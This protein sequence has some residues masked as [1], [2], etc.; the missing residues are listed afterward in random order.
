MR[1]VVRRQQNYTAAKRWRNVRDVV[2]RRGPTQR[3][4]VAAVCPRRASLT[5]VYCVSCRT[6]MLA[7]AG[8]PRL[9]LH[10]PTSILVAGEAAASWDDCDNVISAAASVATPQLHRTEHRP[11]TCWSSSF[12][13]PSA[14]SHCCI[15]TACLIPAPAMIISRHRFNNHFPGKLAIFRRW[16]W[17][18]SGKVHLSRDKIKNPRSVALLWQHN[19]AMAMLF[20]A[21]RLLRGQST[22]FRFLTLWLW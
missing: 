7:H 5:S 15:C 10:L 14:E 2:V 11:I 6:T 18:P 1:C 17:W 16:Q 19:I 22:D 8:P 12:L 20:L 21:T 3:K 9:S 4:K 13:N